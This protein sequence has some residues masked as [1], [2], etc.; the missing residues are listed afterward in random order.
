ML[1]KMWE[2]I[3]RVFGKKVVDDWGL[4]QLKEMGKLRAKIILM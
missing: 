2:K 3:K 4:R 1:K